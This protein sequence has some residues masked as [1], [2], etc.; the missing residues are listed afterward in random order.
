M[1]GHFQFDVCCGLCRKCE[2]VTLEVL[3]WLINNA[4]T[5]GLRINDDNDGTTAARE[6][7]TILAKPLSCVFLCAT[8]NVGSHVSFDVIAPLFE[9][10]GKPK[11]VTIN[12]P[13]IPMLFLHHNAMQN[14]YQCFVLVQPLLKHVTDQHV[15]R[16]HE[17]S[18]TTFMNTLKKMVF[19]ET[20]R[21]I[22]KKNKKQFDHLMLVQKIIVGVVSKPPD[23]AEG[24]SEGLQNAFGKHDRFY[25]VCHIISSFLKSYVPHPNQ[26]KI[27]ALF[28][29]LQSMWSF[30]DTIIHHTTEFLKLDM[31]FEEARPILWEKQSALDIPD[32]L[33][34]SPHITGTFEPHALFN[35][36][37]HYVHHWLMVHNISSSEGVTP[38][39][40]VVEFLEKHKLLCKNEKPSTLDQFLAKFNWNLLLKQTARS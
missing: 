7:P 35:G 16:L 9:V 25:H 17:N 11:S 30:V 24:V 37:V 39:P 19:D 22:S 33:L 10:T 34:T 38:K 28:R 21:E 15:G 2:T 40:Q 3:L 23:G 5:A 26:K 13:R 1:E 8:C 29:N 31:Q 27:N 6:C 12:L 18:W 32:A 14:A 20:I 36:L 4:P